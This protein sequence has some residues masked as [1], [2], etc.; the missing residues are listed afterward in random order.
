MPTAR[1]RV[2][3]PHV[4]VTASRHYVAGR[5]LDMSGLADELGISRATLYRR[6]GN[7]EELLSVVLAAQT[8]WIFRSVAAPEPPPGVG[9]VMEHLVAFAGAV[10]RS[11]PLRALVARDPAGFVRTALGP[12]PVEERAVDLVE[13][14]LEQRLEGRLRLPVRPLAQ[15]LVRVGAW[16][17]YS[18]LLRGGDDLGL[19]E[20][21][22]VAALLLESAV[23]QP[24]AAGA[25]AD[26]SA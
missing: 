19:D 22:E 24:C 5:P 12:G 9:G 13:E 15:A 3:T 8:G 7:H 14:L 2:T 18:R 11:A 23:D 16:V 21:L 4:V 1:S 17:V 25:A 6:V 26:G 10:T 20:A